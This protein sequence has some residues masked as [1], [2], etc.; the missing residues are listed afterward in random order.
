MQQ[1]QQQQQQE[2]LQEWEERFVLQ[3]FHGS[4]TI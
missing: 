3:F 2:I 1:Q 4:R